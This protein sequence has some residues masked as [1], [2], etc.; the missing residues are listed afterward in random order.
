LTVSA[1]PFAMNLPTEWAVQAQGL[2][3]ALGGRT[4]L[5]G[6]DLHIRAGQFV[7]VFGA[8][9]AG[10][11]TLLRALL[12]LQPLESGRL[13]LL[14][15]EGVSARAHIGYV[16]QSDP[17]GADS[18]LRVRS[19]VATAWQGERWGL[20]LGGAQQRA[21]A[22]DAALKAMEMGPLAERGMDALSGGQRNGRASPRRW[23]TRC[24][25]CCWMNRSR[26]STPRRSSAFCKRRAGCVPSRA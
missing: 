7:G 19:F 25:C 22:V 6:L 8:N 17:I 23:S 18:F 3:C 16:S 4:V 9:G 15:Q 20:G 1:E 5:E 21:Q 26:I 13:R 11:T 2:R 12:G 10:K 14:G 24:A